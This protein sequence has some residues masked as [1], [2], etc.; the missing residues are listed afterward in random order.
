LFPSL[1]FPTFFI[2]FL[3]SF[4]SPILVDMMLFIRAIE[5]WMKILKNKCPR[6]QK[7]APK[8]NLRVKNKA[9]GSRRH[10]PW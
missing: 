2:I 1:S 5:T 3:S 8:Q 10:H 6:G 7:I 4:L 9:K